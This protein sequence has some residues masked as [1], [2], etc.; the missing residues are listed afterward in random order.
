MI[1]P[2]PS[3]TQVL[4]GGPTAPTPT[5]PTGV[6]PVVWTYAA[7]TIERIW[8]IKRD[9]SLLCVFPFL[10]SFISGE[11]N[12]Q[13]DNDYRFSSADVQTLAPDLIHTLLSRVEEAMAKANVDSGKGS[14][15]NE[16]VMKC[17]FFL[18]SFRYRSSFYTSTLLRS[19]MHDVIFPLSLPRLYAYVRLEEMPRHPSHT[20]S[21]SRASYSQSLE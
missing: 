17:E 12:I 6:E 8:R 13:T 11:I 9:G 10:A 5:P 15:W 21:G 16:S 2:S 1:A 3:A 14:E 19:C 20:M 4:I 18:D 7:V